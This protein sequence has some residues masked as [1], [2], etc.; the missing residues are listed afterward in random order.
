[1]SNPTEKQARKPRKPTY[2]LVKRFMFDGV[3]YSSRD[4][5]KKAILDKQLKEKVERVAGPLKALGLAVIK[6]H[7]N[8][9]SNETE[10]F[11]ERYVEAII[12][13][14]PQV[15]RILQ[16]KTVKLDLTSDKKPKAPRKPKTKVTPT[17]QS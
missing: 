7:P 15:V 14:G 8:D 17:A 11:M 13:H 3:E 16:G 9:L 12:K 6:A 2:V 1:M 5:V 10:F 4:E